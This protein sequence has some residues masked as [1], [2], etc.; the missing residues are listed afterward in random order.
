MSQNDKLK[1]AVLEEK[2]VQLQAQNREVNEEL[3]DT[4]RRL[5]DELTNK[6]YLD[7]KIGDLERKVEELQEENKE[8]L[9]KL[10]ELQKMLQISD[11]DQ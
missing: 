10:R 5:L 2:I 6:Q 7:V 1:I 3:N 4:L 11:D 9:G 8:L